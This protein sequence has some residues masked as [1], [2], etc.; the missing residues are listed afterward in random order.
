MYVACGDADRLFR[1]SQGVHAMLD[2]KGVPHVYRVIPGGGHDFRVW[3]SDLYHF[4]RLVFR[5]PGQ[6]EKAPAEKAD[7]PQPDK[8]GPEPAADGGKPASTNVGN[9]G[10][11]RVHA[12]GRATFQLKAPDAKKVQVFTNYGLGPRGHW[13]MKKGDDGVWTLTSPTPIVPELL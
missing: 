1:T 9:S 6:E 4:A 5:E 10:Y 11:P 8:K 3:K 2:E 13:D 12:D 7:A